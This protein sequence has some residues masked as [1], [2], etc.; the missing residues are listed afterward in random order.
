MHVPIHDNANIPPFT[1][2][3]TKQ[4]QQQ[5]TNKK[6][7]QT[8]QQQQQKKPKS[9]KPKKTNQTKKTT[10]KRGDSTKTNFLPHGKVFK[11]SYVRIQ[12]KILIT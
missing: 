6:P 12:E 4:Q 10:K 3:K 1:L 7:N 2:K 11:Y 9:K 8:K 5:K